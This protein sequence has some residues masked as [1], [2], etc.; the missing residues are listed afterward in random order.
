MSSELRAWHVGLAQQR[1]PPG[2]DGG[3]VAFPAAELA[4]PR[5]TAAAAVGFHEAMKGAPRPAPEVDIHFPAYRSRTLI[6]VLTWLTAARLAAR[7]ARVTWYLDKQQGPDSF[8]RLLEELGWTLERERRGRTTLLIGSPPA[9]V[10][11]PPPRQ[12]TA[13][14]G[15]AEAALSAR[16]GASQS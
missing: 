11:L 8:R 4:S 9:Q 6:P 7:D 13:R 1:A 16:V 15:A 5:P 12:S 2:R 3:V 10:E 14:R